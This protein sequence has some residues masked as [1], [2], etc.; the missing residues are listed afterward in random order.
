MLASMPPVQLDM[1]PLLSPDL[2]MFAHALF[3][4]GGHMSIACKLAPFADG[5]DAL[6]SSGG[7]C[8]TCSE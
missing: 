2:C 8:A 5:H 6:L 3:S 1:V 4:P 7:G